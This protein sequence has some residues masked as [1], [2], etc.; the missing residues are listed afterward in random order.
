[1][2]TRNSSIRWDR[3][4][5][6]RGIWSSVVYTGKPSIKA[7]GQITKYLGKYCLIKVISN[8]FP[9]CRS[10]NFRLAGHVTFENC[11]CCL[12]TFF[13]VF[14]KKDGSDSESDHNER[15][16]DQERCDDNEADIHP[17]EFTSNLF[18][19]EEGLRVNNEIELTNGM[20]V[21]NEEADHAVAVPVPPIMIH[22]LEGQI[23]PNINTDTVN[24]SSSIC[25]YLFFF[26]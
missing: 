19:C 8:K 6:R 22:H 16:S 15:E 21:F 9:I 13:I 25:F 24:I 3:Q 5:K 18:K 26:L 23:D 2:E 1:M 20:E 10:I 12:L 7:T 14:F 11:L 17:Q 4:K